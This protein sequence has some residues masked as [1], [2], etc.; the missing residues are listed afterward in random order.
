MLKTAV[1]LFENPQVLGDVVREIDALGFPQKEV[2]TLRE[3]ETFEVTGVMT[4]P[5]VEFEDDLIRELSRIGATNAEAEA[6]VEGLRRGRSPGLSYRL[7]R[8][9]T[10]RCENHE[11]ARCV[12][13]ERKQ[14]FETGFAL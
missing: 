3:P 14:R 11:P 5:R 1:A 6:Y 2:R 8:E 13:T 7:R 9:S 10:G 12:G 4:F